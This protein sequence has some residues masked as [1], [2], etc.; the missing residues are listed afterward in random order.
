M[1][2]DLPRTTFTS[3]NANSFS[4]RILRWDLLETKLAPLLDAM[5]HVKP[6]HAELVQM[7]ADAKALEFQLKGQKAAAAQAAIDRQDLVKK[8]EALRSRLAS[9]LAF[10]HGPTS[11]LLKEFGLRP[12]R[13]GGRKKTATPPPTPAPAAQ[14][15]PAPEAKSGEVHKTTK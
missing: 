2:R 12:R 15:A 6:V 4:D 3:K 8:G 10:E 13:A 11:V 5:P 7:L 14:P 1:D 9:A